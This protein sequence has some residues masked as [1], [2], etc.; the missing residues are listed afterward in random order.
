M[1]I[2]M[3]MMIKLDQSP[4]KKKNGSFVYCHYLYPNDHFISLSRICE[5]KWGRWG[6]WKEI[7]FFHLLTTNN[8]FSIIIG[9]ENLSFSLSNIYIWWYWCVIRFIFFFCFRFRFDYQMM[10]I[11]I[12]IIALSSSH[13][14]KICEKKK[15]WMIVN[16]CLWT[17]TRC[18][19]NDEKSRHPNVFDIR[20]Y[21]LIIAEF[22]FIFCHQILS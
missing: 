5:K 11:I 18:E 13:C 12:I 21:G 10:M 7:F 4:K 8:D 2:R 14:R 3:M 9:K 22:F 17:T 6:W 20:V 19:F 15:Y 1:W 16:M